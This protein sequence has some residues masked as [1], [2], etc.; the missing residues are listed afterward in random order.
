MQARD[1][2]DLYVWNR[3][4]HAIK[5]PVMALFGHADTAKTMSAHLGNADIPSRR[6]SDFRF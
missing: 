2:Q 3:T 5:S 6:A 1:P 4:D